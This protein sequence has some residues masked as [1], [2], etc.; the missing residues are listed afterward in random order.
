M[1]QD[2]KMLEKMDEFRITLNNIELE[3]PQYFPGFKDGSKVRDKIRNHFYV[4]YDNES[5]QVVYIIVKTVY[6]DLIKSCLE[7]FDQHF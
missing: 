7:L 6:P 2:L 3:F 4:K 5:K 1:D